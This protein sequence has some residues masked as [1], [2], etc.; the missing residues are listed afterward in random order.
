MAPFCIFNRFFL[1]Q[2][3]LAGAFL[4]LLCLL[5]TAPA[6]ADDKGAPFLSAPISKHQSVSA[7]PQWK[8]V[9]NQYQKEEDFYRQCQNSPKTCSS[10]RIAVWQKFVKTLKNRPAEAQMRAVNNWF[11]TLPY[12]QDNW[13]YGKKDHWA[14]MVEFL[15]FSGDCEDYAIAKYLTL[16]QLGFDAQSLRVAM[17]YD[18]YS[19]TDHSFLVINHEGREF[20]LDNREDTIDP[21]KFT[22]RYKPHFAFN[23]KTIWTYDSPLMARAIRGNDGKTVLTGNR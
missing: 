20:I 23:E 5:A 17:V 4:L 8:R 11:N 12:R 9:L 7:L 15:D 14:S 16:K 19:G 18:V 13:V 2:I 3:S 6:S 21:R 10:Q 22:R 1:R